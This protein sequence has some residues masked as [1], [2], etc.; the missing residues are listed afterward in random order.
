MRKTFCFFIPVI[1][2][3]SFLAGTS[4]PISAQVVLNE[5]M[6]DPARDWDGDGQ[7]NYRDDEWIEIL[8]RGETTVDISSL[9]LA[10]GEDDPVWRFRF[11]GVLEPGCVAIVFGSD[12]RSW[13]EA[14]GFPVYGLSLNNAGDC[15]SLYIVDGE[16]TTLLDRHVYGNKETQDDRSIGRGVDGEELWIVFDA[17]NPMPPGS[18]PAGSG[19][20]PTPGTP[21]ACTTDVRDMSWGNIKGAC[22]K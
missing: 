4:G 21:N 10:D 2:T 11:S 12:S 8:N 14:N 17:Y 20:V 15:V 7:Y 6:A 18:V 1:L 13:E 22:G 3:I 19:C 9:I 16:D 5:L